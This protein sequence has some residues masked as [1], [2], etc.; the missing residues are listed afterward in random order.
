MAPILHW[1]NYNNFF[2]VI[3]SIYDSWLG[4]KHHK[5]R[6]QISN[7]T[8]L[9][10]ISRYLIRYT[11]LT[12]HSELCFSSRYSLL[13]YKH[14]WSKGWWSKGFQ[15]GIPCNW[16]SSEYKS[17]LQAC[18]H[19]IPTWHHKW[20]NNLALYLQMVLVLLYQ[21]FWSGITAPLPWLQ[22]YGRLSLYQ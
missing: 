19:G 1:N 18:V 2:F 7:T 5:I 6:N 15:M 13:L 3:L 21:Y 12:V 20:R 16:V 22:G 8:L 4:H 11:Q 9:S 10:N 14:N 17:E